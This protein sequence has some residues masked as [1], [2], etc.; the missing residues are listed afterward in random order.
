MI[1][2][3]SVRILAEEPNAK[4]DLFARLMRDL[5]FSIGYD[6][7]RM[8]V[9]RSGREIDLEAEH[10]FEARRAL[11]ECKATEAP[12]G[13]REVNT[14]GGKLRAERNRDGRALAPYFVSLSGFTEPAIDQESEAGSEAIILLDGDR[15]V[16]ELIRGRIIVPREVAAIAAGR[17]AASAP[18]LALDEQVEL[19]AHEAGWLWAFYFT[20]GKVRTHFCLVHGDGTALSTGMLDRVVASEAAKSLRDLKPL[21]SENVVAAPP[22]EVLRQYASYLESECG[23]I[24][25][26]GL[27]ADAEVGALRLRLEQLFV[28][29]QLVRPAQSTDLSSTT[30]RPKRL[31]TPVGQVLAEVPRLAILAVPGGGK[32]TLLNRLA[33]A[34]SDPNRRLILDDGLPEREWVPLLFRCRELRDKARA[35]WSDLL[36]DL[37]GRAFVA[38]DFASAFRSLA[39]DALRSGRA[40]VLIDGLDELTNVGDRTG[41]VRTLR[42]LAATYPAI[43]LVVTSRKAGFRHVASLLAPVCTETEIADLSRPDIERL[44]VAWHREVVGDKPAVIED[45]RRLAGLIN[46][47]DRI[48]RLASNPLLLTTLLLVKRW[49]GQLPSRRSVL[50]GKAV[51]VLLMTWNVEG[52]D[53]IE[54]D[55]ALP[56]LCFVAFAM[57]RSGEQQITR[58][59]LT[60]LLQQSRKELSA[61]LAFARI[62][63]PEFVERIEHRSSLLVMTGHEVVDGTL[64]ELYEFRHL[65]FQEYLAARAVV[66]GWYPDRSDLDTVGSVL[67]PHFLDDKWREV[68]PL[69]GTLAGRQAQ[70]LLTALIEAWEQRRKGGVAHMLARCLVDEP[71]VTPEILN[72]SFEIILSPQALTTCAPYARQIA[73][74][75][76]GV[77]WRDHVRS[78]FVAAR[79]DIV[80]LGGVLGDIVSTQNGLTS[81]N[82]SALEVALKE[83]TDGQ[84][85]VR[86]E[87]ALGLLRVDELPKDVRA[88]AARRVEPLVLSDVPYERLTGC[89][90]ISRLG[91]RGFEPGPMATAPLVSALLDLWCNQDTS[92]LATQAIRGLSLLPSF[93]HLSKHLELRD[94]FGIFL[95][96]RTLSREETSSVLFMAYQLGAPYS[97]DQLEARA[98]ALTEER[99]T[100]GVKK[101]RKMVSLLAPGNRTGAQESES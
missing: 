89:W 7:P 55:E 88:E 22:D 26:E 17:C 35:S 37:A 68:T 16:Q 27:P 32:S 39:E 15:V 75:K 76:Y 9:A 82:Q 58:P 45:A 36:D 79:R 25:L 64:T 19:L 34:Y 57:M 81:Q 31:R 23:H 18:A 12:I 91:R 74:T 29:L 20:E 80:Q 70:S 87:A 30:R 3:I 5:F 13:G 66:A 98:V 93:G 28:P 54:Q 71:N 94:R 52:H 96:R 50:Y 67:S 51:E 43:Q 8:N 14:F 92:P 69:A 53:P 49:V 72:K 100:P 65:T 90:A 95:D 83:L 63:I 48:R 2:P 84:S 38:K 6:N 24:L 78:A 11:A 41:F 33:V 77:L 42:T 47:N 40:L 99:H 101:L 10:R 46:R 44:T 59:D 4:G 85:L 1:S 21:A 86:C 62:G 61:E 56:Q 60:R 97:A 73:E